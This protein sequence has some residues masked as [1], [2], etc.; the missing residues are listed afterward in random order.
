[1]F[2]HVICFSLKSVPH[3]NGALISIEIS[4]GWF[5]CRN[6]PLALSHYRESN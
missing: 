3:Q 2:W 4:D 5:H 1:M 6:T